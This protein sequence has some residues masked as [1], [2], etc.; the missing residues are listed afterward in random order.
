MS[1]GLNGVYAPNSDNIALGGCTIT[2]NQG[3]GV[4]TAYGLDISVQNCEISGNQ[5]TGLLL[6]TGDSE[7][8]EDPW[9]ASNFHHNYSL[10]NSAVTGNG[11]D[12]VNWGS[13]PVSGTIVGNLIGANVGH[14]L[15]FG[16]RLTQYYIY[17]GPVLVAELFAKD[18]L[19]ALNNILGNGQNGIYLRNWAGDNDV[20][21]NNFIDNGTNVDVV[22]PYKVTRWHT[23]VVTYTYNERTYTGVLGN[24]WSD[25]EGPDEDHNG[26]GDPPFFYPPTEP[27][28]DFFPLI[29]PFENYLSR[30]WQ[31]FLPIIIH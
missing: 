6:E 1:S 12:G 9:D 8:P 15:T 30:N 27:H 28:L 23:G 17:P 2:G 31:V 16:G 29:A 19:I 4:H 26:V 11:E 3:H 10:M 18:H 22:Q 24:H 5:G 20:F 7:I 21:L 14:G 13:I 25:Y